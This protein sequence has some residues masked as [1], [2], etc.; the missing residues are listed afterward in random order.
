MNKININLTEDELNLICYALR[1]NERKLKDELTNHVINMQHKKGRKTM[2][3]ILQ[4]EILGRFRKQH[5]NLL[6]NLKQFIP[7]LKP[8]RDLQNIR[9]VKEND[10]I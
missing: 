7:N 6:W 10:R 8:F 1:D 4:C 3:D 2:T 5:N 9:E